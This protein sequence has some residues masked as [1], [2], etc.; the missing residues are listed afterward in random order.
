MFP[1][2][3]SR[4]APPPTRSPSAA[5]LGRLALL[6]FALTASLRATPLSFSLR[7]S[8]H[9][10]DNVTNADRAA[11]ERA[12]LET[13]HEFSAG[14]R[15]TA[16]RH[17]GV[18]V[19]GRALA[20]SWPRYDGLDRAALGLALSAQKK[21]GFGPN[22]TVFG[23]ALSGDRFF[24]RE[25]GRAGLAGSA[26][27]FVRH[28]FA[29][30]AQLRLSREYLRY[31]AREHAFDRTSRDTR[32]RLSGDFAGRWTAAA[33]VARRDGGVLSYAR[34]PHPQL[35]RE[36]KALTTVSTFD[37]DL[38]FVAYYFIART[39]AV[40][41]ELSRVLPHRSNLTF[42]VERRLTSEGVVDYRNHV[43]SLHFAHAF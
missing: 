1:K 2:A 9:W 14:H 31:D 40:R 21:T 34:P 26:E 7:S 32:L 12:A 8:A 30:W 6:L 38:P 33:T 18:A 41:A 39:Y 25:T 15:W 11:D 5:R 22:T 19:A 43:V 35:L 29:S 23:A 37:A 27:V 4:A 28:R 24:A 17:L 20:E 3:P 13:N 16:G 42:A 36:G 10:H